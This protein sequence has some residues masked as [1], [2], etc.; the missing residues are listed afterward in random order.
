MTTTAYGVAPPDPNAEPAIGI[1]SRHL[2]LAA[3][4]VAGGLALAA[5]LALHWA[6]VEQRSIEARALTVARATVNAAD[7]EVAASIARMEALG[8]SPALRAGDLRAFY[9]QMVATPVPAA[10]W[11]TLYDLDRQ[12][13]NTRRPFGAAPL[14]RIAEFDPASQAAAR[15]II[16]TREPAVSPVIWAPLARTHVVAVTITIAVDDVV[17]HLMSAVLSD[18][19]L[20]AVLEEQP[21]PPD[22]QSLLLDR[23]GHL[24]A[25]ARMAQRPTQRAVPTDWAPQLRGAVAQGVFFGRR[26]DASF[27]I[28]FARSTTSDWTGLVEVPWSGLRSPLQRTL[29]L[30]AAGGGLLTFAAAGIA[31]LVARG[32]DRPVTALRASAADARARQHEA[33]TRYRAY[34]E[35]A[36]EALFVV[37]VSGDG[38]F[39]FEGTN[40]AHER[41][42]GIAA[43][44]AVGREPQE[45]LPPAMAVA[46]TEALHRC[47]ASDAPLRHEEVLALPG[48]QR[49]WETNLAPVHDPATG[50]ILRILGSARDVT[51]R[52]RAEI[53]LRESVERLRLAQ[54]AAAIGTWDWDLAT[55][56]VRWTSTLPSVLGLGDAEAMPPLLSS[57]PSI[58]HPDDRT[59]TEAEMA[60]AIAADRTFRCEF[61]VAPGRD[62]R[63]RWLLC[64]GRL[65][66]DIDPAAGAPRHVLGVAMDIT[67]R[68]RTEQ[69]RDEALALFRGITETSPDIVYIL[70]LSVQRAVYVNRRLAEVLGYGD[71]EA[72]TIAQDAL[73]ALLH[74]I[75]A[76]S[77]EM[78]MDPLRSLADGEVATGAFRLRHRDGSWR[79]VASR[80]TVFA[81]DADG[82]VTQILGCAND[83]TDARRA[84]E[85]IRQLGGRLLTMQDDERRR[86]ARELHDSTAQILLGASF[87]AERARAASPDLTNDADDAI[88]EV[89][90]L[91][92]ESQREIRTLAYL[93]HP[94][95]LD[96]MGL[97]TA[98][99]WYV[100]GF[101]RR[102][103]LAI[104]VETEPEAAGRRFPRDVESAFFRIA[105]EALGNALRHAGGSKVGVTLLIEE[106]S[107]VA[108]RAVLRIEDD[109]RGL[110]EAS[111]DQAGEDRDAGLFG[112]GLAGMRERMHQLGGHLTVRA[113]VPHGTIIEASMPIDGF[114]IP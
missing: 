96:E 25:S 39:V 89:L 71:A 14:P 5:A 107:G 47:V 12:I 10:T 66:S 42:S 84:E 4:C 23:N 83:T 16:Q 90:T 77:I 104:S 93:L 60:A 24:V 99:R 103:G 109:G 85:A 1:R 53:A 49:D 45:C 108:A 22:W 38:R 105:Q 46:L 6:D 82:A 80:E 111:F 91:I 34:W 58:V 61:R 67:E 62:D 56:T 79:W 59:H 31:L 9:D 106:E 92:E 36:N 57:W 69:Q 43:P 75:D 94:P 11:L 78:R 87:A 110:A 70:D 41:L 65:S 81:R 102:S 114:R 54:E 28:A 88:E 73:R 72:D 15:R 100:K 76:A 8:T 112:V 55:G 18:R 17:R 7:R 13:L 33:E 27:L 21:L 63:V 97:P 86:I 101:A 40:P 26:D 48:G 2:A 32:T 113:A 20:S 30:L 37:S 74:P 95:L 64:R 51:D 19:R 3:I 68:K 50:N 29:L 52:R 44:S 98:L 35:H